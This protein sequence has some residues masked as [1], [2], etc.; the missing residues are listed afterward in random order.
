MCVGVN[1]GVGV[2]VSVGVC[3][4]V[5]EYEYIMYIDVYDVCIHIYFYHYSQINKQILNTKLADTLNPDSTARSCSTCCKRLQHTL[6][7][8]IQLAYSTICL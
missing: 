5:C 6:L 3:C 8:N 7:A 1:I 2:G 4:C